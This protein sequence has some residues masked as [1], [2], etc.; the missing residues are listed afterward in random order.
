YEGVAAMARAGLGVIVE[1]V[2]LAGGPAQRRI[3]RELPRVDVLWVGVRCDPA[4]A[5]GREA[6]RSERIVGM[7]LSQAERVHEG[8]RYD[9]VVDTTEA[10]PEQCARAVLARLHQR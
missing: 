6:G 4:V 3:A 9:V 1:E 5:A 10:S 2:L 8:V 7:A